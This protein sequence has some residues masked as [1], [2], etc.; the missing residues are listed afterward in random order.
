MAFII[1]RLK[2]VW[3]LKAPMDSLIGVFTFAGMFCGAFWW[4]YLA[5]MNGRRNIVIIVNIV[6]AVFG[7][8]SAFSPGYVWMYIFRAITGFGLG[9]IVVSTTLFA[10]YCPKSYRG[11]TLLMQMGCF[12]FG[13]FLSVF[14]A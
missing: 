3:E 13:S 10:E 1:P 14:L 5:D 2:D 8:L 12:A 4:S 7:T 9:G 6:V 11:A